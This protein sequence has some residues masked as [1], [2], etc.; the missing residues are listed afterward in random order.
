MADIINIEI[1]EDGTIKTTTDEVSQANHSSADK[2]FAVLRGLCG[3]IFT[4]KQKIGHV[5]TH[6]NV[7]HT[8]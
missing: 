6:G 1:L 8:H 5:H 3:G 7:T 2:F 4:R